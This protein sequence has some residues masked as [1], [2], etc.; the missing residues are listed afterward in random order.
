MLRAASTNR[1][2][3]HKVC[4]RS[5]YHAE[6]SESGRAQYRAG[7]KTL[8]RKY[9]TKI[10]LKSDFIRSPLVGGAGSGQ[11]S[12]TRDKRNQA[13]A[14]LRPEGCTLTICSLGAPLNPERKKVESAGRSLIPERNNVACGQAVLQ[15]GTAGDRQAS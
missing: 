10:E 2:S 11:H 5:R 1:A 8:N 14:L 7:A 12:L 6:G 4:H 13:V 3:T 9:Q 15:R